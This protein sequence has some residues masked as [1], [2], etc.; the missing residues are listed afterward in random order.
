MRQIVLQGCVDSLGS[1]LN[2]IYDWMC[3]YTF[4]LIVLQDYETSRSRIMDMINLVVWKNIS[5][6]E[7]CLPT[8]RRHIQQSRLHYTLIADWSQHSSSRNC[9]IWFRSDRQIPLGPQPCAACKVLQAS[10]R[11]SRPQCAQY[12]YL[13]KY[14]QIYLHANIYMAL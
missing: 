2:G 13:T 9:Y 3:H 14:V 12:L 7:A 5:S 10:D 4:D 8:S 6:Q 11:F 1:V